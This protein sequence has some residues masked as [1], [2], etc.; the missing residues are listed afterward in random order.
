MKKIISREVLLAYP[1]F[2]MNSLYI[3]MLVTR[4]WGCYIPEG[5]AYS[6][7]QQKAET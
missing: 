5:K 6:L 3:Q 7:L 4:N 2:N 1:D